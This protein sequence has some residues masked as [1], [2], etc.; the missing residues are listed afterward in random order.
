VTD[1]NELMKRIH[2]RMPVI[3]EPESFGE[4]LE[5]SAQHGPDLLALP[6]LAPSKGLG[7]YAVS[8]S[9]NNPRNE[10]RGFIEGL[11][12]GRD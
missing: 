8:K 7:P 6:R 1:A 9:V 10:G 4:W 5:P 3:L 2:E 12:A 11:V